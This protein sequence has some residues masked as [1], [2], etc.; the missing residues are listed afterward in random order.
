MLDYFLMMDLITIFALGG[1]YAVG[2]LDFSFE[3]VMM[4]GIVLNL[5]AGVGVIF[6]WIY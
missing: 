4:L 2:T 3:E 5:C 1:V 6:V